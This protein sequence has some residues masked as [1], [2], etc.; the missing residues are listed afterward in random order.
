VAWKVYNNGNNN[1]VE[2]KA[3]VASLKNA[4]CKVAENEL[5]PLQPDD[6]PDTMP[7]YR[8]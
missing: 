1:P 8:I 6:V 4:L 3:Y 7:T 5:L 2:L